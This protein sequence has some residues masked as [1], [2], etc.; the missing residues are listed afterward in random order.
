M[1]GRATFTAATR[2]GRMKEVVV[3]MMRMTFLLAAPLGLPA[4][5]FMARTC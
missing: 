4:M 3:V 2:N 1:V 5:L